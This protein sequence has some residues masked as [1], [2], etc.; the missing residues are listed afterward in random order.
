MEKL[1]HQYEL[2]AQQFDKGEKVEKVILVRCTRDI[3]DSIDRHKRSLLC[4]GLLAARS[5]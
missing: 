1:L 5:D 3:V 4:V 2:D